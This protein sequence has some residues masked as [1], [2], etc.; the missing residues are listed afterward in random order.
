MSS[1]P[2]EGPWTPPQT[3]A[4]NQQ[5][6]QETFPSSP[7]TEALRFEEIVSIEDMQRIQDAFAEAAGV[8]SLITTPDGIPI[9]RPSRFT[10]FCRDIV[11]GTAQGR[12]DCRRSDAHFGQPNPEGPNIG[13][14]RSAGLLDCGTCIYFNNRHIATWHVGQV[15]DASV[16]IEKVLAYGRKIGVDETAYRQALDRVPRLPR[17]RFEAICHALYRFANHLSA[18]ALRAHRQSELIGEL[19]HAQARIR[20]RD[21]RLADIIAFLPDPTLVVD[22][23]GSVVFWNLA[24]EQ[25]TGVAAADMLGKAGFE[26]GRA[27]YGYATPLLV[28]YARGAVARPDARYEVT[29]L[30]RD[31]VIAEVTVAALPDGPRHIW[32]KAVALRDASGRI[33]GGI[34]TIRDVTARYEADRALRESEEKFRRIVETANEG[35]WVL[36]AAHRTSF[37]NRRLA[38]LLGYAPGEMLGRALED[39]VSQIGRETAR[40]QLDY[41]RQGQRSVGEQKLRRKDGG[42]LW[43]L[44]SA[45]PIHDP[46]GNYQGAIGMLTDITERKEAEQA[47]ANHRQRLEAEVEERTR[48]LRLQAMELAEA[49]IRLSELDRMKS[50]FLSTVS[51]ELRTPLTSILGFAKLIGRDFTEQFLPLAGDNAPLAAKGRRIAD[52]LAVVFG[53]AERLTRLINDVLDLSRIESGNMRWNDTRFAPTDV[54]ARAAKTIEGLL[55]QRPEVTFR[56]TAEETPPLYMDPDQLTQVVSNLLQNAVKFT[57]SGEVRLE[58]GR[59]GESV[60]IVVSDTG[61]GIPPEECESIFEKFHQVGRGDTVQEA[62]KGMGLGLAI[63]RQ[64]V[65][66]YGGRIWVESIL[67]QGSAFHVRLP[68]APPEEEEAAARQA[69]SS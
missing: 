60:R 44:L 15:L 67:G 5:D 39:F 56:F 26:Y 65:R 63:C 2:D 66:H 6:A 18:M 59:D 4:G 1:A 52:N 3:E 36:D 49:N 21:R 37:V 16:D 10:S 45:S 14:C 48:D 7:E 12:A 25:L 13:I 38:D 28:D 33:R 55:T 30:S 8:A 41:L 62:A 22:A 24:M 51:H 9:T 27:F 64:I 47:L 23:D 54:L 29:E 32:A 46:T 34:E 53:E 58:V 35:V 31:T 17:E 69:C 61:I 19:R 11:R 50:V 68:A 40:S 43:A 57:R 42:E 20:E